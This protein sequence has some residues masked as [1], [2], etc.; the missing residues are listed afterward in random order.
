MRFRDWVV[1]F[2]RN[3]LIVD[4]KSKEGEWRGVASPLCKT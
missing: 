3:R 1:I 2:D 4:R